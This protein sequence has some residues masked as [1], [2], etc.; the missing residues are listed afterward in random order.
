MA[1]RQRNYTFN[2]EWEDQYCFIEYKGKFHTNYVSTIFF[3]IKRLVRVKFS[4]YY[5]Y[6]YYCNRHTT[7]A[8]PQPS[9][10]CAP[11]YKNVGQHW[12]RG[13]KALYFV[14]ISFNLEQTEHP[15]FRA[16]GNSEGCFSRSFYNAVPTADVMKYSVR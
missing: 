2:S 6:Y 7:P 15:M 3:L 8:P 1:K 11:I 12:C 10:R 5:Y 14:F 13:S 16:H 9:V 4:C